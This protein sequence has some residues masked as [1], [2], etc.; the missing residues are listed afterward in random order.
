MELMAFMNCTIL[1]GMLCVYFLED[2]AIKILL[3]CQRFSYRHGRKT[4]E[5]T[6]F[7]IFGFI[8]KIV[9]TDRSC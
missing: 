1:P 5:K 9:Q 6:L 3:F 7:L 8:E 4:A 2:V